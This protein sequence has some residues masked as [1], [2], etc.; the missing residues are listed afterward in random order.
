MEA[1]SH[2][3]TLVQ[4]DP[5]GGHLAV[6]GDG[7][8]QLPH[9]GVGV[10]LHIELLGPRGDVVVHQNGHGLAPASRG[11]GPQTTATCSHNINIAQGRQGVQSG[12]RMVQGNKDKACSQAPDTFRRKPVDGREETQ[13]IARWLY[14]PTAQHTTQKRATIPRHNPFERHTRRTRT[15]RGRPK[16]FPNGGKPVHVS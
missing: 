8:P 10:G 11:V 3:A 5:V 12:Q 14:E 7:G 16:S 6:L 1:S 9:R 13:V 2:L 15:P 4:S